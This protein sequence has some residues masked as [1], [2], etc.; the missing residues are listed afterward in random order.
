MKNYATKTCDNC[1]RVVARKATFL[2]HT[3]E[4]YITVRGDGVTTYVNMEDSTTPYELHYCRGCWD[5]FWGDF[6]VR[7]AEHST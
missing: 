3:V 1:H 6:R 5:R 7:L 2:Y 4:D